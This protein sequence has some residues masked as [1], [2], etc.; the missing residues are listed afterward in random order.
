MYTLCQVDCSESLPRLSAMFGG[1]VVPQGPVAGN[2]CRGR[3]EGPGLMEGKWVGRREGA[4]G[5][6]ENT[7]QW[8]DHLLMVKSLRF[9]I[10]WSLTANNWLLRTHHR[11]G[12]SWLKHFLSA[13]SAVPKLFVSLLKIFE[14]PQRAF[15]SVDYSRWCDVEQLV[16]WGKKPWLVAL[17]NSHGVKTSAE[18]TSRFQTNITGHEMWR[19]VHSNS[20]VRITDSSWLE[21]LSLLKVLEMKTEEILK[22]AIH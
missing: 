6:L 7:K 19:H 18:A 12:D 20:Q 17:A 11:G 10:W 2:P 9:G 4:P 21:R 14:D 16:L 5:T 3:E 22:Y 13:N 15:V 8:K 1:W